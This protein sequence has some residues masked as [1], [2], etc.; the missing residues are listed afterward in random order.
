[1]LSL[2]GICFPLSPR[3]WKQ[4]RHKGSFCTLHPQA[5]KHFPSYK[6]FCLN[7]C[8]SKMHKTQNS[9]PL[10]KMGTQQTY[11]LWCLILVMRSTS[12]G[13]GSLSE[14]MMLGELSS[15]A[16]ERVCVTASEENE[17]MNL[18]ENKG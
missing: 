1:M 3:N 10:K 15:L 13:R 11:H 16:G 9:P 14:K 2:L 18:K 4:S 6:E 5:A 17:A 12:T 7:S 8:Y